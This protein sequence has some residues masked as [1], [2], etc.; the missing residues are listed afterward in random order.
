MFPLLTQLSVAK[1][2]SSEK[3]DVGRRLWGVK[4]NSPQERRSSHLYF[5][6]VSARNMK[7]QPTSG[8]PRDKGHMRRMAEQT[9]TG[10]GWVLEGIFGPSTVYL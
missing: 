4:R 5:Y 2:N 1:Y 3:R 7:M 10:G 9:K 6:S 8:D